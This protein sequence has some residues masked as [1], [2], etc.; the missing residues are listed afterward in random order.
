MKPQVDNMVSFS[1]SD[2]EGL[3]EAYNNAVAA[4]I[5]VFT[6]NDNEYIVSYAKYLIEYLSGGFT[7]KT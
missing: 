4:G 1:K 5:E 6:F 2:Y 3:Q 7:S